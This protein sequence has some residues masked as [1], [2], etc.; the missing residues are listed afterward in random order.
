MSARAVLKR[1]IGVFPESLQRA[2]LAAYHRREIRREQEPSEFAVIR[3]LVQGAQRIVDAGANMGVY[4]VFLARHAPSDCEIISIEPIPRTF[5]MLKSNVASL[6]LSNVKAV[7][8][9]VTDVPRT[10]V[11]E[12]PDDE[13]GLARVRFSE[14]VTPTLSRFEVKAVRIDDL[15]PQDRRGLSFLKVDVEMHELECLRGALDSIRRYHPAIFVEIQP[16]LAKKRS[17]RDDIIAMLAAEGYGTYSFDSTKIRRWNGDAKVLD[18]FF[19]TASHLE[20]LQ[21]AGLEI[22]TGETSDR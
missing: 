9:A 22:V 12:I 20:Q 7:N 3:H 8:V 15:V 13:H 10:L 14:S 16:D 21:A 17:Q 6:G 19:L 11:M 5:A 18:Y 4:S 2:L 1:C